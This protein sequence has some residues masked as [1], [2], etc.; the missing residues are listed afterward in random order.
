MNYN[1]LALVVNL[2]C[3]L[4]LCSLCLY[5][6]LLLLSIVLPFGWE[7]MFCSEKLSYQIFEDNPL[8]MHLP[9]YSLPIHVLNFPETLSFPNY[10]LFFELP[11]PT[12]F[13]A[14]LYC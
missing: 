6:Y 4:L 12:P 13:L 2:L 7:V 8:P 5:L 14:F 9:C 3:A 11:K 1:N 10:Y